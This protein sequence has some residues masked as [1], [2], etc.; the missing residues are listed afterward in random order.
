MKFNKF[1]NLENKINYIC[2]KEYKFF[3]SKANVVGIGFGYKTKNGILTSQKTIIVLVKRKYP[4]Q[5]LNSKDIIPRKYN[6]IS[7]D[8]IE[9]GIITSSSLKKR[10]RPVIGGYSIGSA[11]GS[12]NGTMGCLVKSNNVKFLLS[13][14]HVL[15]NENRE[16]LG[17]NI[18]QPAVKEGGQQPRDVIGYLSK[19]ILINFI[20]PV[21]FVDCALGSLTNESIAI[22]SIAYI[23]KLKGTRPINMSDEVLKVGSATERTYGNVLVVNATLTVG[24]LSGS[25]A[26]FKKQIITTKMTDKGD[27]GALLLDKKNYALGLFFAD[28]S[29]N[30]FFNTMDYVLNSLN[31]ELVTT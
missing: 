19:Y 16:P 30:S 22:S 27:S 12:G 23:G 31:V 26:V 15:A 18:V 13:N 10:I 20:N 5:Y 3:F 17:N 4:I 6:G 1:C 24:F 21:N 2:D 14:N 7:T 25:E 29:S 28:S 8:V 9:S 11:T